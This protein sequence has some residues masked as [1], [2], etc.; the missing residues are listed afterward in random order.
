MAVINRIELIIF[1]TA[2]KIIS[3]HLTIDRLSGSLNK[4]E[5]SESHLKDRVRLK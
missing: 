3:L 2:G 4:T 1:F 5:E